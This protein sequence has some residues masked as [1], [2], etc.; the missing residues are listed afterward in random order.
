M[1]KESEEAEVKKEAHQELMAPRGGFEPPST[2]SKSVV[3]TVRR[4]GGDQ[5]AF[6][7]LSAECA[8]NHTKG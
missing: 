2:D 6:A 1:G 4:P 5:V 7:S 8:D 3:L